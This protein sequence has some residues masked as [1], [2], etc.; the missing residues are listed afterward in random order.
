[1]L[2]THSKK[3]ITSSFTA[4]EKVGESSASL[5]NTM[6]RREERSAINVVGVSKLAL[7]LEESE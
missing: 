4:H 2:L 5:D 3:N 6:C 7:L 1:M